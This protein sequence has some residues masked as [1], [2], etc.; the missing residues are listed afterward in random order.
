MLLLAVM[1]TA[2]LVA[3]GV[4]LAVEKTGT[5][6]GETLRGT[7]QRIS[8]MAGEATTGCSGWQETTN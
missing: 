1:A 2:I 7:A 8:S 5:N 3:A 6:A 4:A